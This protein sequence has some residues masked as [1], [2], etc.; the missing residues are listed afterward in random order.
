MIR[1]LLILFLCKAEACHHP[2]KKYHCYE[3]ETVYHEYDKEI[4]R[5]LSPA[6][7]NTSEEQRHERELATRADIFRKGDLVLVGQDPVAAG[8]PRKLHDKYKEP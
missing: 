3:Q 7:E 4:L 1:G 8:K 2:E 5:R 6:V